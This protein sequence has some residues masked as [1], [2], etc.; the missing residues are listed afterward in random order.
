MNRHAAHD[1]G[2][3][4]PRRVVQIDSSPTRISCY[5]NGLQQSGSRQRNSK[6]LA[7]PRYLLTCTCGRT[8]P[9]EMGQAGGKLTCECG[10]TLDVPPLRNLRHLPIEVSHGPAPAAPTWGARQ[11]ILAVA[12]IFGAF[13]VGYGLWNW[14]TEPTPP[15]FDPAMRTKV[16]DKGIDEMSPAKAWRLSVEVY[17]PLAEAGFT[18]FEHP[19]SAPIREMVTQRRFVNKL[20]AIPAALC[21]LIALAALFWPSAAPARK[22]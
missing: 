17:Q 5:L 2:Y 13:L 22:V 9:V 10:E 18:E 11:Q 14:L 3:A 12:C 8:L 21:L 15:I 1:L 19:S 6:V 16:M 7:M 20:L 4:S